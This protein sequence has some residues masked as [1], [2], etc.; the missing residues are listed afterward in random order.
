MEPFG[1]GHADDLS[2]DWNH[3]PALTHAC[4]VR[5]VEVR[6]EGSCP[7]KIGR[8][9][10]VEVRLHWTFLLLIVFVVL[11]EGRGSRTAILSDLA[12][13]VAVFGSVLIHELAHSVVARGR[14]AAV[15]D[16]LLTP[17]GGISQIERLP[18][19]ASDEL[20]IAIVGP[21]T[22]FVLAGVAVSF[23]FVFGGKLWPPALFSGSWFFRLFWLNMLLGG[24]NML[25]A[26]PMDGGRVLRA[27]LQRRRDRV[28]ATKL[29][30]RVARVF[31]LI[32]IAMGFAFDIWLVIIGFFVLLGASAEEQASRTPENFRQ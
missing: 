18:E 10:G 6:G 14:G 23:G 16:I 3:V 17:I 25:P 24:F 9:F 4:R 12:W 22:S 21:L 29:A 20:A 2:G 28:T 26:L 1:S 11:Q 7:V 30:A 15:R 27:L 31:A 8:I 13:I 5:L 32:M 19:T